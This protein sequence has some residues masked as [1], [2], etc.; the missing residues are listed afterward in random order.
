MLE[1]VL[2]VFVALFSGC[3]TADRRDVDHAVAELDKGTALDGDVEVGDVVE[4]P[5]NLHQ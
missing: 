3:V 1:I 5:T 2:L 4:D